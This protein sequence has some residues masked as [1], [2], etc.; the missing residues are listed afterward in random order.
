MKSTLEKLLRISIYTILF[1]ST[2]FLIAEPV[3]ER[4]LKYYIKKNSASLKNVNLSLLPTSINL[5]SVGF[6]YES[7]K[8]SCEHFY[9][10]TSDYTTINTASVTNIN[11]DTNDE[12][13]IFLPLYPLLNM[14]RKNFLFKSIV[15]KNCEIKNTSKQQSVKYDGF[16]NYNYLDQNEVVGKYKINLSDG[17]QL[18][19]SAVRYINNDKRFFRARFTNDFCNIF[20]KGN[21]Q[22]DS[23]MLNGNA[24]ISNIPEENFFSDMLSEELSEPIKFNLLAKYTPDK[25]QLHDSNITSKNISLDLKADISYQQNLSGKIYLFAKKIDLGMFDQL[26]SFLHFNGLKY[27]IDNLN[28]EIILRNNAIIRNK[29]NFSFLDSDITITHKDLTE[30]SLH[31]KNCDRILAL[32]YP[33]YRKIR[34]ELQLNHLIKRGND[35]EGNLIISDGSI[36]NIKLIDKITPYIKSEK[37]RFI[38]NK[39]PTQVR[40]SVSTPF[41]TA[42]ASYKRKGDLIIIE[43][44]KLLSHGFSMIIPAMTING[45]HIRGNGYMEISPIATV[46]GILNR[47]PSLSN[48]YHF[49]SQDLKLRLFFRISGTLDTPKI[50]F[51]EI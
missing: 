36:Y 35:F 37:V 19:L 2:I 1:L 29:I 50:I 13:L 4:F 47:L 41:E 22:N 40:N 21:N 7:T 39:I 3:G 16:V 43:H 11:I 38:I 27:Y 12:Q 28:A 49:L 34:G 44:A 25:I 6:T 42:S 48:I 23:I 26:K 15:F 32:L 46:S 45:E 51:D 33:P 9:L 8:V 31:T 18:D 24:D 5:T 10:N 14:P 17:S 20:F 30:I